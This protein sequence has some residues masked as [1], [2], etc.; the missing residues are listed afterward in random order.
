MQINEACGEQDI[1]TIASSITKKALVNVKAV[2]FGVEGFALKI[3]V[4]AQTYVG[5]GG[6]I[7]LPFFKAKR[8]LRTSPLGQCD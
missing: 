6:E 7:L 5:T 2:F 8:L 1:G 3:A 4:P